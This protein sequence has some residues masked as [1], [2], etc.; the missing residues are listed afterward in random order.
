[1]LR[2]PKSNIVFRNFDVNRFPQL[3]CGFRRS[4]YSLCM[5]TSDQC[6]AARALLRISQDELAAKAK[7]S[8]VTVRKFENQTGTL[9]DSLIK[10][11]RLTLEAEGVV[12]IDENGGGPG[13]RLRRSQ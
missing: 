12:F 2:F 13:V 1:M 8:A 7:I 3:N 4:S 6:R 9:R 5:I 10:L 11:I